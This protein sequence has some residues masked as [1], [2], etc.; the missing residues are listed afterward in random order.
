MKK[1]IKLLIKFFAKFLIQFSSK[2]NTGRY[3]IDKLSNF[4]FQTKKN[5]KHNGLEL[6]FYTPNRLNFY[7]VDTFSSKEPETLKWI[8][9]FKEKSVFW[10]IGANIGLYSCYAAKKTDCQVYAFE[11]SVFNLELL[12]KNIYLN[13]LSE[14]IV[15]IP[16]PLFDNLATKSFH[17]ST[18]E[19]GGAFSNFGASTDHEGKQMTSVFKYKTVGMSI[20]QTINNLNLK[21]PNYI[22][23]DVDGIEHLIIKGANSAMKNVES[24]LIEVNDDY[25]KQSKE[26]NEHLNSL[27][28]KLKEKKHSEIIEKSSKFSSFYNQIWVKDN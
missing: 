13:S 7:R 18:R 8:D 11:P 17:M 3:F 19:R 4:I 15:I 2:I 21:M 27:G 9:C 24:I 20:D 23:M 14:K 22:K 6:S 10:D 25:I 1:I 26:I 5:I 28:F 16:L 12:A